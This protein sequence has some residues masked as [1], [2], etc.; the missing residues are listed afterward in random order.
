M[1]YIFLQ[2]RN[3]LLSLGKW[4]AAGG[5]YT[6]GGGQII[7]EDKN[8]N[9]VAAGTKI[10]NNLYRLNL[11]PD[12]IKEMKYFNNFIH[13]YLMMIYKIG[14]HGINDMDI[15]DILDYRNLSI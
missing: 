8:G 7:L 2:N 6:G 3:N 13:S 4:D 14:K 11:K 15:L 1:Y 9:S 12:H 10:D 5:K